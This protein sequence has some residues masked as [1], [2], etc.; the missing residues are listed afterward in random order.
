MQT[1]YIGRSLY[2][3]LQDKLMAPQKLLLTQRVVTELLFKTAH[4]ES[5]QP[6]HQGQKDLQGVGTLSHRW[7]SGC[8][9]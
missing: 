2:L 9:K 3:V 6:F 8:A 1:N 5:P 4:N 7:R